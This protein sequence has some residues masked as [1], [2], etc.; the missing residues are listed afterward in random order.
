MIYVKSAAPYLAS[1]LLFLPLS[2]FFYYTSNLDVAYNI[3]QFVLI[4]LLG[5]WIINVFNEFR[6]MEVIKYTK[7]F[8]LVTPLLLIVFMKSI[9][10]ISVP[11]LTF[12]LSIEIVKLAITQIIFFVL[13]GA[14]LLSFSKSVDT[15]ITIYIIFI[16]FNIASKGQLIPIINPFLYYIEIFAAEYSYNSL[17]LITISI[18]FI[19][20]LYIKKIN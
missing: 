10:L 5:V 19:Y 8:R 18:L 11:Y 15:A 7:R 4:P 12:N 17:N 16:L 6:E 14:L 3:F 2:L 9:I 1:Y 13:F 20:L